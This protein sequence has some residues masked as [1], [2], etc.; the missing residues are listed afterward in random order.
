MATTFSTLTPLTVMSASVHIMNP[1][2]DRRMQET[3]L[4]YWADGS[5]SL[6]IILFLCRKACHRSDCTEDPA[7][8]GGDSDTCNSGW[9]VLRK[10]AVLTRNVHEMH[11]MCMG[12][13]LM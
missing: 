13:V 1:Q 5:F 11:R 3:H 7:L 12:N 4:F 10:H 2:Q 6:H 9:A 8:Q